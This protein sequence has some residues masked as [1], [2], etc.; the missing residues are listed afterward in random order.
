MILF[1]NLYGY[2]IDRIEKEIKIENTKL[3]KQISK[4]EKSI[5]RLKKENIELNKQIQKNRKIIYRINDKNLPYISTNKDKN[6]PM[7]KMLSN[8]KKKQ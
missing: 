6:N 3:N 4:N 1:I 8:N 7:Y 5:N 2:E